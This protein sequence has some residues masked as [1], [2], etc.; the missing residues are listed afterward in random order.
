MVAALIG[1]TARNCACAGVTGATN[2]PGGRCRPNAAF[3]NLVKSDCAL[4]PKLLAPM[5][6]KPLSWRSVPS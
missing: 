4:R 5:S 2:E 6:L 1:A 3:T